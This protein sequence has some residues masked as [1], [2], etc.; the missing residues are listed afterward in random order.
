MAS[1]D[2]QIDK[3]QRG[4]PKR[5]ELPDVH[6]QLARFISL[7]HQDLPQQLYPW[8]KT[9]GANWDI[10]GRE[11]YLFIY[12]IIYLFI[13][14]ILSAVNLYSLCV[15][16]C[17]CVILLQREEERSTT[18]IFDSL[19][20]C[21]LCSAQVLKFVWRSHIFNESADAKFGRPNQTTE[22]R[23]NQTLAK[24]TQLASQR[25]FS[26]CVQLAFR[27]ATH[28]PWLVTTCDEFSRA[29]IRT[30]VDASFSAFRHPTQVDTSWSQV[31]CICVK[32]MT[33]ATCV[34][35]W[36]DLWICLATHRKSARK[37][38]FRF[39]S[40]FGRGFTMHGTVCT[41]LLSALYWLFGE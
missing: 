13:I 25:K 38:W 4:C 35:L 6:F 11:L 15:C 32:F 23:P 33:F 27:L 20:Q 37:L 14:F 5:A 26:T 1:S 30:Q 7:F 36:A 22:P 28:L 24:R 10:L 34:N 41:G 21:Y 31:N 2:N 8:E 9:I 12:L 40:P 16:V 39:A 29:Q 17:V 3:S 18:C 19:N